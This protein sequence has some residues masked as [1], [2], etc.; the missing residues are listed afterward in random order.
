MSVKLLQKT[1]SDGRTSLYLDIWSGGRRHYEFLKLYPEKGSKDR[2]EVL[3]LG[4]EIRAKRE[5]EMQGSHHG[6]VPK[7]KQVSNFIE[8]FEGLSRTKHN[9]WHT[10]LLHLLAFAGDDVPFKRVNAVWLDK[11]QEYLL[12]QVS[13]NSANAYL[14]KI[15]ASLNIAVKEGIIHANP[16][17]TIDI[18]KSQ[19]SERT[20]LTF[21]ELQQLANTPI[22]YPDIRRAFLFSCYTGLRLSDVK[23]LTGRQIVSGQL[24][25]RQK[26]TGGFEYLPISPTAL[27]LIEPIPKQDELIF[28]LPKS[29]GGL[30]THLQIW[31]T[32]AGIT[33][34]VSFHV[35]RHTFATLALST[36]KD[37]YLVSKLLGHKDI[38]HTQIYARIIDSRKTEAVNMI[39]QITL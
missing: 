7:F 12:D 22:A 11:F 37:I 17:L 20:Y 36:S 34:H 13:G 15:K 38:K 23:G 35:A 28:K 9:T 27:K 26:K 21:E 31:V 3:Q 5:L 25:Y 32:R 6:Y 8:F 10:V 4:E 39:P 33:K 14:Q 24:Q 30:W 2:K 19:Q 1:L 18:V 16:C 29:E